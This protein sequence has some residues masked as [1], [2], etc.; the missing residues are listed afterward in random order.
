MAAMRTVSTECHIHP[1]CTASAQKSK[2]QHF[3]FRRT[4]LP[5]EAPVSMVARPRQHRAPMIILFGV[6]RGVKAEQ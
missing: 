4:H 2:P 1:Y 3:M 6:N 5:C